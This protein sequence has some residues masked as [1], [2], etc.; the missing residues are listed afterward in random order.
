[1]RTAVFL[2]TLVCVWT[3]RSAHAEVIHVDADATGAQDGRSWATAY[4][5][6]GAALARAEEGDTVWVAEGLYHPDAVDP[7]RSFDVSSGVAILGGFQGDELSEAEA[8]P[9]THVVVLSGDLAGDDEAFPDGITYHPSDIVGVNTRH[10]VRVVDADDVR[11][12]GVVV[13]GGDAVEEGGAGTHGAGV[14]IDN[15]DVL[16]ERVRL[17]GN[18]AGADGFGDG[19]GVYCESPGTREV[20]IVDTRF[21]A[22]MAVRRGGGVAV[23]GCDVDLDNT[24]FVGNV[25]GTVDDLTSCAAPLRGGGALHMAGAAALQA[26]VRD[27]RFEDNEAACNG[28]ALAAVGVTLEIDRTWFR[29]NR[30][31][32]TDAPDAAGL[33]GAVYLLDTT[34]AL[35]ETVA[36][37]NVAERSGGVAYA[38]ESRVDFVNGTFLENQAVFGPLVRVDG[39]AASV[40]I[41][42]SIVQGH[43]PTPASV[44]V[45]VGASLSAG[46]R[47]S[48][49]DR[50][51]AGADMSTCQ[52]GTPTF[53]ETTARAD[54]MGSVRLSPASAGIGSGDITLVS[55]ATDVSG[56]PRVRGTQVDVGATQ[57]A[58][59]CAPMGTTR[60]FAAMRPRGEAMGDRWED[61]VGLA[62]ALAFVE[63]CP[64]VSV[65]SI[66]IEGGTHHPDQGEWVEPGDVDATFVLPAYVVVRGGFA[67][68]EDSLAEREEFGRAT[69]LSGDLAED[70]PTDAHGLVRTVVGDNSRHVVY[71]R[72][73]DGLLERVAITGGDA[74]GSR[75][76][77][78]W[79]DG[80][81]SVFQEVVVAGNFAEVGG[82]VAIQG[83]LGPRVRRTMIVG[84]TARMHGGGIAVDASPARFDNV[85]IAGNVAPTGAGG[86]LA[87]TQATLDF[88]DVTG[89]RADDRAGGLYL[90]AGSQ[91]RVTGSILFGNED[92]GDDVEEANLRIAGSATAIW[93][94]TSI[95]EGTGGV[96]NGG[97]QDMGQNLDVDPEFVERLDAA[98][99]PSMAG[100]FQL[101]VG[102]PARD[103]G[104]RVADIGMTDMSR[105]P[106]AVDGDGDGFAQPDIGAFEASAVAPP[107]DVVADVAV[108]V[109]LGPPASPNRVGPM[110]GGNCS[111]SRTASG[112][113][114]ALLPLLAAVL[115]VRRRRSY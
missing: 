33:G 82:G 48:L 8:D 36:L 26:T 52:V 16:L 86:W 62:D 88:I 40:E 102:S 105:A 37:A 85:L 32:T 113:L 58:V 84:N 14:L 69:T 23:Y 56:R 21:V 111:V 87:R 7:D 98:D 66:W 78:L 109:L 19:A 20:R 47:T 44:P 38:E 94:G 89:N 100:N 71:V 107:G 43:G 104:P 106:R 49:I 81:N 73:T 110:D 10:V 28:G 90:T 11:I 9:D 60:L 53:L 114:P 103:R 79:I 65:S 75:G 29:R 15:A 95:V 80:S 54:E 91:P 39:D 4:T 6:L 5:T 83:D 63:S 12:A 72:G 74:V 97:M 101:R 31:F 55:S 24:E 3:P 93:L 70:D 18:R 17:V 108:D 34:A 27:S 51:F 1:M 77:G 22:N 50:A 59:R 30:A 57:S 61:A 42:N 45:R 25:A 41:A 76:G 64:G 112:V 2:F 99:A 35:R 92:G 96:W 67:G 115:F 46:V 68:H 13:T